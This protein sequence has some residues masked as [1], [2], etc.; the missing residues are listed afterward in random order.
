MKFVPDSFSDFLRA[1]PDYKIS[2]VLDKLR[3]ADYR[4]LDHSR[5]IYLDYTGGS[6]YGESQIKEHFTLLQKLVLGN[7]HSDNP[8]SLM[9]TKLVKQAK[10]AVLDF[11]HAS[12]EEYCIVFTANASNALKLVGESYPFVRGSRFLLTSDNHNSVNGI[13]EFAKNCNAAV[14]YL[15]G[16]PP[17]MRVN[18]DKL[19]AFLKN[20]KKGNRSSLFAFPA[21]S[22]FTGIQYP[23]EWIAHAKSSGWDVFLDAAAFVP[24]NILDLSVWKADFVSISFY[25]M[26]GYPTGIGCLIA[27]KNALAKLV[28]PWFAGGT[29]WAASVR[30]NDHIFA[31]EDE[32][33]EDG[34]VN[35]LGIPAVAIGL[36]M[37]SKVGVDI[38]HS[39]VLILTKWLLQNMQEMTHKNGRPLFEIYG[40]KDTINRGG[41]IAFNFLD[42]EGNIIDERI[43][44]KYANKKNISLRTGCFCNPGSGEIVFRLEK[45][46]LA[47]VFNK[48]RPV[49]YDNY[50][51]ILGL[52]S[53]GAIR[54]SLGIV[55]NF[56]DVLEFLKFSTKF[57]DTVV[58]EKNLRKRG[59]C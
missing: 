2:R 20:R 9:S 54:L 57:Q 42:P 7:P 53:G 16:E 46:K 27:R 31:P 29:I 58:K 21:Q 47:A 49:D 39:R 26:F 40:P 22:N 4:R 24:T 11:F 6:L 45:K 8:T 14:S 10:S 15:E 37:L 55:S 51:K 38:I 44:E 5:Q 33:F 36:N 50:L 59:H 41:T 19:I 28:R 3:A 12:P 25:K 1:F 52:K 30:A 35:Y 17:E 13:R 34:T 48:E 43:V 32:A 56:N 23:L 18:K